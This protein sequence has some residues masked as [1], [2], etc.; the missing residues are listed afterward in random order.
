MFA[1]FL[2]LILIFAIMTM[3]GSGKDDNKKYS[4]GKVVLSWSGPNNLGLA[5]KTFFILVSLLLHLP[6]F[7][8]ITNGQIL[9]SNFNKNYIN[10]LKLISVD[11]V[12]IN[13]VSNE[14]IIRLLITLVAV[15]IFI[16]I[17]YKGNISETGIYFGYWFN[18]VIQYMNF[19]EIVCYDLSI[20]GG[21]YVFKIWLRPPK[22]SANIQL[23]IVDKKIAIK[24][25]EL[26]HNKVSH[27][28]E[29][30]NSTIRR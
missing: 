4:K 27:Y 18:P 14:N 28:N 16:N 6:N 19:D 17:S 23:K 21:I 7:I 15:F 1:I 30:Q 2:L 5:L 8:V 25:R 9:R 24:I 20:Y 11:F 10:S 12:D 26:L 13:N 29:I 3:L 22:Y